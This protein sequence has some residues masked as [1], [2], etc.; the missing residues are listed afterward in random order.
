MKVIFLDFDGPLISHRA[1]SLPVHERATWRETLADLPEV[2][3]PRQL[4]NVSLDTRIPKF[5]PVAVSLVQRL[6]MG[7]PAMLVITSSWK[8]IGQKNIEFILDINGLPSNFLHLRWCTE[9]VD[10]AAR[11]C[12]E[13]TQWLSRASRAGEEILSYAALDDDP[14]IISLPG[15]VLV[16]YADGI[17]WADFCSASAALG[18]GI[19]INNYELR[20]GDL[21]ADVS[22]GVLGEIPVASFGNTPRSFNFGPVEMSKVVAPQGCIRCPKSPYQILRITGSNEVVHGESQW[23]H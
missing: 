6:V 5:D 17:R 1:R 8:R 22:A 19:A 15:G 11:R 14:S 7:H 10:H 23:S 4:E 21:I 20:D 18:H 9:P 16:P 2:I 12:D 3:D 13:I